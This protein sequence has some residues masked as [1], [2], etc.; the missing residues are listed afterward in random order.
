[1]D[2]KDKRIAWL[3]IELQKK[4]EKVLALLKL[5]EMLTK[6]KIEELKSELAKHQI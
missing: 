3:E 2:E 5:F 1:M 6:D 4:G